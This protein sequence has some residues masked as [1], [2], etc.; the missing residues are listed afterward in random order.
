M[1]NWIYWS[2]PLPADRRRANMRALTRPGGIV[3]LTLATALSGCATSALD[4]APAQPDR[5][6]QPP[7]TASGEIVPGASPTR[8]AAATQQG[9]VLPSNPAA[10]TM[11][12]APTIDPARTYDLPDL[13]DIA[14]AT[15][16]A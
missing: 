16:P 8:S 5:P 6:W 3:T 4:R 13:I 15:N 2:R 14:E 1:S 11:P 7:T 9:Y 10:A 12:A